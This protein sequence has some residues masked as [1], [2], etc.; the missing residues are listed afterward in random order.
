MQGSAAIS[1]PR[2]HGYERVGPESRRPCVS[3]S[4]TLIVIVINWSGIRAITSRGIGIMWEEFYCQTGFDSAGYLF[5]RHWNSW[6]F[7]RS[8]VVSDWDRLM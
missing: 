8:T 1:E 4:R 6:V 2:C 3:S 7:V 5:A